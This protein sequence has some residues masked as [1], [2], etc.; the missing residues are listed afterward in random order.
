MSEENFMV[1]AASARNFWWKTRWQMVN[2]GV[3]TCAAGALTG[4]ASDHHHY[5]D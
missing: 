1:L 2:G 5:V 4:H 3:F